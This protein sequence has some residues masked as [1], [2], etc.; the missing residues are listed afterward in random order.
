MGNTASCPM[1]K[2]P[3]LRP[4]VPARVRLPHSPQPPAHSALSFTSKPTDRTY[5]LLSAAASSSDS[6][7]DSASAASAIFLA[8]ALRVFALATCP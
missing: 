8:L 2:G 3:R 7:S 6:A 4:Q 1:R 5:S